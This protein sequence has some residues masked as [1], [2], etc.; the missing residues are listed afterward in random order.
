[1][2]NGTSRDFTSPRD[3]LAV[4]SHFPGRARVRAELFRIVP[5]V[6]REVTQRIREEDGV[7][8][9]AL[10]AVTGS[11]LVTYDPARLEL[12]RLV[13]LFVR[14]ARLHG[15]AAEAP[16]LTPRAVPQGARVRR[17]LAGLNASIQSL[18]RGQ[19]DLRTGIPG[20]LAAGGLSMLV[21]GRRISPAWY[22]LAFW[23]FVTFMNLNPLGQAAAST[24]DDSA[25]DC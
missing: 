17:A 23:S 18:S 7:L 16:E 20:A 8:D 12:A 3:R 6:G 10:S 1:M 21:F 15:V 19:L 2:K 13:A 22:D 4:L 24:S 9:A 14:L 25:G 5:E 11:I